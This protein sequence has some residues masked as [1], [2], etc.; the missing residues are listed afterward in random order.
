M[1]AATVAAV[2]ERHTHQ[3]PFW[4]IKHA[5]ARPR[6][7]A[8]A[9]CLQGWPPLLRHLTGDLSYEAQ[10]HP[11]AVHTA[12]KLHVPDPELPVLHARSTAVQEG[13]LAAPP[14]PMR[15]QDNML[16]RCL[17]LRRLWY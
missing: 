5:L 3:Y 7:R 17:T 13:H 9:P 11:D 10:A 12:G 1:F 15:T 14:R 2:P 4:H 16:V 8:A 6:R